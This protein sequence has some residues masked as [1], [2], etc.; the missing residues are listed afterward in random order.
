MFKLWLHYIAHLGIKFVKNNK[1][2]SF[3]PSI[4]YID[5]NIDTVE[6]D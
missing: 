5:K 2:S 6:N 3:S 1:I 4:I